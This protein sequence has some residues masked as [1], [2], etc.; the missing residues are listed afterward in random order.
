MLWV[1]RASKRYMK[2][3]FQ[4]VLLPDVSLSLSLSYKSSFTHSSVLFV[5]LFWPKLS[6]LCFFL[7]VLCCGNPSHLRSLLWM[8]CKTMIHW[9]GLLVQFWASLVIGREWTHALA[10]LPDSTFISLSCRLIVLIYMVHLKHR[11]ISCYF[12]GAV[13]CS[14]HISSDL[15]AFTA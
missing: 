4:R 11:I 13:L 5:S 10:C 6:T 3:G 15:S 7:F 8:L 2:V 12:L 14:C 1:A 9:H